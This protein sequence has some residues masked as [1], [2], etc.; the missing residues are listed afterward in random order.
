LA[1]RLPP[2][3]QIYKLNMAADNS[4]RCAWANNELAIRYHDEEWGRPVH[5]DRVLFE[6]LILE[7]AQAGL[8]WNTILQKREN[9][10][11]AF[12]GFDP[13][14]VADYDRRKIQQLLR[15]PGIVRN[16]LKIASA[17]ENAKAFLRVQ[18]EFGSFDRYIWQFVGGKPLVNKRKSLRQVPAKTTESDAMSKDLK[19]RGFNFVGSTIC[20][21]FMQATGLVN[22][23]IVNCHRYKVSAS[24]R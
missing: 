24:Q 20:Y 21:A 1:V 23:H 15:D 6:F 5:D 18:Q 2:Y 11:K 7:G 9:Y 14:R 8:S 10:R 17:V 12:D 3:R 13:K 16:K 4:I 19:R 22:D